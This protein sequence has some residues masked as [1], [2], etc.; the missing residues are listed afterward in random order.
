[1]NL[2]S[3]RSGRLVVCIMLFI[4]YLYAWRPARKYITQNIVYPRLK[5]AQNSMGHRP[6]KIKRDGVSL[7]LT[8]P[9]RHYQKT[10]QYRPQGGFFFLLAMLTLLV[11]FAKP[12]WYLLL[13]GFHIA[14]TLTTTG[15]MILSKQGWYP[16]FLIVDWIVSYLVPVLTLAMAILFIVKQKDRRQG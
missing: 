9:W 6:Y 16:G 5:A 10:I 13:V 7:R 2:L 14:A 15:L 4:F 8:F 11:I 3:F 12:L 1:M